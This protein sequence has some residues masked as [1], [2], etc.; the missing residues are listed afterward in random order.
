MND[1]HSPVSNPKLRLGSSLVLLALLTA[2][3]GVDTAL[4]KRDVSKQVLRADA[5]PLQVLSDDDNDEDHDEDEVEVVADGSFEAGVTNPNWTFTPELLCTVA[6]CGDGAGTAGSEDGEVWAWFG[7]AED[8]LTQTLEQTVTLPRGEAVLEFELWAG[9]LS[10]ASFTFEVSLDNAVVYTLSADDLKRDD[11]DEDDGG[12]GGEDG[13]APNPARSSRSSG[14]DQG[15]NDGD[16][17]EGYEDVEVDVSDYTDDKTHTLRF[18]FTK[19]GLGDTNLSL[20]EVSLKV[21]NLEDA[22]QDIADMVR[23]LPLNL[24]LERPLLAK[25]NAATKA[26]E[27]GRDNAGINSLRAFTNQVKAQSKGKKKSIPTA[28]ATLLITS[29]QK[30]IT[31]AR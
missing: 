6:V 3:G 4:P 9:A 16:Y 17:T 27:R 20:D 26:F 21:E 2:C 28:D 31:I 8:A 12:D 22:V 5:R 30:L 14:G 1:R 24:K 23:A 13:D 7:G 18:T 10:A 11:E 29:A 25:L 15:E 19:D